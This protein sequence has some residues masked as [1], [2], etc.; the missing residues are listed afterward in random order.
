MK[1]DW[2]QHVL[3]RLRASC[4]KRRKGQVF[5]AV[6]SVPLVGRTAEVFES[7]VMLTVTVD[8]TDP[9][10]T[11]YSSADSDIVIVG[12]DG[13]YVLVNNGSS[14]VI[15]SMSGTTVLKTDVETISVVNT[16]SSANQTFNLA[17]VKLADFTSLTNVSIMA[18]DGDDTI[19]GSEFDD[20]I[21]GG[22]GTDLIIETYSG[23]T[24][25]SFQLSNA[26]LSGFGDDTLS[27]IEAASLTGG[28]GDDTLDACTFTAGNV[29]LI[30]NNGADSLVGGSGDDLL[31][32]NSGNDSLTGNAGSDTFNPGGGTDQ[33]IEVAA[34]G[35]FTLTTSSL[36]GTSGTD[37]VIGSAGSLERASLTGASGGV[38]L[39]ASAFTVSGG[40]V[41]LIGGSG[42]DTLIGGDLSGMTNFLTGG[43]G[44]D[45]ITSTDGTDRIVESLDDDFTLT[46][47][48]L[49][50]TSSGTDT[51]VV[52]TVSGSGDFEEVYLTGGA[53][54]NDL[55]AS[56][57][58][59]TGASVTLDG[60]GGDDT[61]KGGDQSGQTNVLTGG[62]G[63]DTIIST[64]GT[65]RI[66]ESGDVDFTLTSSSLFSSLTGTDTL[67]TDTLSG[68]GGAFEEAAIT[69]GGSDNALD[70]SGFSGNVTLN[71]SAGNDTLTGGSGND[72][73]EG[74]N[75]A[76]TLIGGAGAD[77]LKGGDGDDALTG[78]D[79]A[80]SIDGE[81]D[82]DRVVESTNLH[83]TV[84]NSALELH[85]ADSG[86]TL[87]ETDTLTSVEG[88]DLSGGDGANE[89]DASG[90]TTIAVTLRGGG[91]DDT[92]TGGD[93][94]DVLLGE[95][96]D[97]ELYG[98]DG[99]DLIVGGYGADT[100]DGGVDAD[101]LIGAELRSYST[102]ALGNLVTTWAGAGS[103][104]AGIAALEDSTQNQ[105]LQ[106]SRFAADGTAQDATVSDDYAVNVLTGGTDPDEL[107]WFIVSDE[108]IYDGITDSWNTVS[109]Q[110]DIITDREFVD[111]D[112]ENDPLEEIQEVL[113]PFAPQWA[114]ADVAKPGY[115][116]AGVTDATY[117]TS[118]L[119]ISGD[120]GTVAVPGTDTIWDGIVKNR[121][122][123]DSPWS[124][125][126]SQIMLQS[127]NPQSGSKTRF[128]L[129]GSTYEASLPEPDV[130]NGIWRWSRDPD[131]A[132]LQYGFNTG[133]ANEEIVR[134][135]PTNGT[136]E[137]T[138]PLPFDMDYSGK[139]SI[140]WR[141]GREY[142]AIVGTA[143]D[144]D[145]YLYIVN[146]TDSIWDNDDRENDAVI[147][148]SF[149]LSG[150]ESGYPYGSDPENV[151]RVGN[152]FSP[153]GSYFLASYN[154]GNGGYTISRLLQIDYET[155]VI[156]PYD[157]P[158][159]RTTGGYT[160]TPAQFDPNVT[161]SL[162][163][164]ALA[165]G[166]LPYSAD[167]P[168]FA[169]ARSGDVYLVSG[170]G[171]WNNWEP[172]SG[173]E[174]RAD[175]DD[176]V[177]AILGLNLTDSSYKSLTD[178]DNEAGFSHLTATNYDNPG[179]VFVSY[180]GWEPGDT[181]TGTK[182]DGEIIAIDLDNPDGE[183]GS[184]SGVVQYGTVSIVQHRTNHAGG[185]IN[186]DDQAHVVAS[187]DGTQLMFSSTWD[188]FQNEVS[189]YVVNLIP[190][191]NV[192]EPDLDMDDWNGGITLVRILDNDVAKVRLK[193]SDTGTEIE[194]RALT[195]FMQIVVNADSGG[196]A[197]RI[198]Y[199]GGNPVPAGGQLIFNGD[200]G[201]DS[202]SIINAPTTAPWVWTIT[203]N[204][205]GTLHGHGTIQ[206]NGIESLIGGAGDD[207][208]RIMEH[209]TGGSPDI[210]TGS[211]DGGGSGADDDTL[212]YAA[213]T[214]EVALNLD[215]T[216]TATGIGSL[217][218]IEHLTGGTGNDTI[219]GDSGDNVLI[220]G[221]GN[222]VINGKAGDDTLYGNAGND[223]LLGGSDDDLLYIGTGTDRAVGNSGND[224]LIAPDEE[225]TW[226]IIGE[227]SASNQGKINTVTTFK[228]IET[229]QGGSSDDTFVLDKDV[230]TLPGS[231]Y[232]GEGVD[233]LD[234][235]DFTT[236]VTAS[237]TAGTASDAT[238]SISISGIEN[239][240]GGTAADTLT[241]DANA[242]ILN[243]NGG[244]D[245]LIGL[246]GDDT[247]V[248]STDATISIDETTLAGTSDAGGSDT[249]SYAAFTS[250]A[251][252]VDLT[253][254]APYVTFIDSSLPLIE[255][256]I[257]GGG[258]DTLTGN[259]GDNI[260]NGGGGNDSLSGGDGND[261]LI[262]GDG[263]D[264]ID[265]GDDN[266]TV[267]GGA[268]NDSLN[269][270]NGN[271]WLI[272]DSTDTDDTINGGAGTDTLDYSNFESG[273]EFDL[274]MTS[275]TGTNDANLT[276]IEAVI[277]GS[278]NDTLT[279][280][281]SAEEFWG[282][283]GNDC[284]SG[285]DGNDTIHGDSGDDWLIGGDGNDTYSFT[286][287]PGTDM[288]VEV[289]SEGTDTL[290]FSA[291]TQS[292]EFKINADTITATMGTDIVTHTG[293]GS[294]SFIESLVGGSGDDVFKFD[295][296][297]TSPSFEIDG[298]AKGSLAGGD[299]ND[300]V[301]YSKA[302]AGQSIDLTSSLPGAGSF[303]DIENVIGSNSADTITGNSADN[304][305]NGKDGNDSI[306]GGTGD[307]TL[308]GGIG[309]DTL[310][311]GDDDDVLNGQADNDSLTGGNEDDEFVYSSGTDTI[312]GGAGDNTIRA[313]DET[314][315]VSW[316]I[317]ASNAGTVSGTNGTAT[318]S[319]IANLIGGYGNDT[320]DFSDGVGVSGSIAGGSGT[321]W[322]D[323]S[324]YTS[325]VTV[326]LANGTATGTSG[327]SDIERI[328]GGSVADTL[329]GDRNRNRIEG[330]AGNDTLNG[331]LWDDSLNGN[332][333]ADSL[334][335]ADGDDT[336]LGGAGNDVLDG[337]DG[338]D[339]LTGQSG[340]D[341]LT[342]GDGD[343]IVVETGSGSSPLTIAI[344]DS[345]LSG[346]GT[347]T[348]NSDIEQASLT[349][350]SGADS[351][352]AT[353]FSGVVTLNGAGGDDTLNGTAN[354]D[355]LLGAGGND[356]ISA[357]AGDD[358]ISGGS[359]NDY[360]IGWSGTDVLFET[361]GSGNDTITLTNTSMSGALGDDTLTTV[362]RAELW[363]GDGD[364]TIS[365]A[366]FSG[367][368]TLVGGDGDDSLTGTPLNDSL[369]GGR[370][371]DSLYGSNG[372]DTINGGAGD[373]SLVG[374]FGDDRIAG[375]TG[376]DTITGD[377]GDDVLVGGAGA[378]TLSG[379]DDNDFLIGD[380]VYLVDG[381]H[382]SSD[383]GVDSVAGD[384]DTDTVS[385][386]GDDT[387]T[388]SGETTD[389]EFNLF[390]S[391]SSEN[392]AWIDA[393]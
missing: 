160:G 94:N 18:G 71:G 164:S 195:P 97:D 76:D 56:A 12:T 364:D 367:S 124:A 201:N 331:G 317:T 72:L 16:G 391:F 40:S 388:L 79:G 373:D 180:S 366:S 285:G 133:T 312:D 188:E 136:S 138:L 328:N 173:V 219:T 110:T 340:N 327:I 141:D 220:G 349:G 251:V 31:T 89:L 390:E 224:T 270:N 88:A 294:V 311:G 122:V 368:V 218:D 83:F 19:T 237:L 198:D 303:S 7:R 134:F 192:W 25:I 344:T 104:A 374:S 178:P 187:P 156:T 21:D 256:V 194:T 300:W 193:E 44:N 232:G 310:V 252:D 211:I 272:L 102:G 249:L 77:T 129:D 81:A 185:L 216:Q 383:A 175:A 389:E 231:M 167:H 241:G 276:T 11:I 298:G 119:R 184:A 147:T 225:N 91:G 8:W 61:L 309:D 291:A 111:E 75:A 58:T 347:D 375:H 107:D 170:S 203:D 186:Y 263:G 42:A 334:Q 318:F 151:S 245:T 382:D 68:G 154:D 105:F 39:D 93:S 125:D 307:D 181:N 346:F 199:S 14:D 140:A 53:S 227:P 275:A 246:A 236:A 29:T 209:D 320:F 377:D 325:T 132:A 116:E 335:G 341:S 350:A 120:A 343:D 67:V 243:G 254:S 115:L 99:H 269:G 217:S 274:G 213:W 369:L 365:A 265:G 4:S 222:D 149:Q 210:W 157:V 339:R 33:L 69:G 117:G 23:S 165:L 356:S 64:A 38:T 90:A 385:G 35:G 212:S 371:D 168:A 161:G 393:V 301:D 70:A 381:S 43:A 48:S 229:L 297:V 372:N 1:I 73:L 223:S 332:G 321:D 95:L 277:G 359:G 208:F 59:V 28:S 123:T 233:H 17:E 353:S 65:D 292:V 13:S 137:E 257:G 281:S 378:D 386:G 305:L 268:G 258:N 62:T 355:L 153:E 326:D 287:N 162:P 143:D 108:Q 357:D 196:S 169:V 247:Y 37:S 54:A 98:G 337:G 36:M 242:N 299:G 55:D 314:D 127:I 352:T 322:L 135:D 20:S 84:T 282:G 46:R 51:L 267:D 313:S 103:Y 126:G 131:Q 278:G 34:S 6:E 183:Y 345:S 262:G 158:V 172:S 286:D 57:F 60:G 148:A 259:S 176:L 191:A 361:A 330:G 204:D 376:D 319:Y 387:D 142:T 87:I 10:L 200:S 130:D 109:D 66:V 86:R 290:D 230:A 221:P 273:V 49:A 238:R 145:V 174:T 280:S 338:D 146:L 47:T 166:Y 333:D 85:D 234:F 101:I 24:G 179:Y 226:E 293:A 228:E 207:E 271:D 296:A 163:D 15:N 302:T 106:A 351:L 2:I 279:G 32:G 288:V 139:E 118:I 52:D 260:L 253:S 63:N 92:L 324:D 360:I 323:Y 26:L 100:L 358:T 112:P 354:N 244:A 74:K 284:I 78:G 261:W 114:P 329:T 159:V 96:G 177:G 150:D 264:T 283:A 342:G 171:H 30:G 348:L 255:N 239:V 144:G 214:T 315:A 362:E 5:A 250:S 248:I 182:Y 215:T 205:A 240:T 379:G 9:V 41:T 121:Y 206:F 336:L 197:L 363:G 128:L 304:V 22:T 306:L 289:T 384:A 45:T 316:A 27:G 155:G 392:F 370:G 235:S 50:T 3:R 380:D 80:D 189:T 308:L 202:L 190:D 295:M 113:N 266:D 152:Y 82:T